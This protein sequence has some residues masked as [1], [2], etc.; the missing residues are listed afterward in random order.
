M[1]REKLK[2]IIF[3][4][5]KSGHLNSKEDIENFVIATYKSGKDN[6]KIPQDTKNITRNAMEYIDNLLISGAGCISESFENHTPIER[7]FAESLIKNEIVYKFQHEIGK[8]FIDFFIP[9]NICIECDGM[10]YH[11]EP[12][13]RKKDEIKDRYLISKGFFVIRFTGNEITKNVES[14]TGEVKRF[15]QV[16]LDAK[17]KTERENK[18]V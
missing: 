17:G 7:K 18:N 10:L 3:D 1:S 15:I 12:K 8:Y 4:F 11:S 16:C 2:D 9:P 13:Q 14:C 6:S 5:A